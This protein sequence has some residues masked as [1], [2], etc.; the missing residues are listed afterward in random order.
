MAEII[1][2]THITG[3][4]HSQFIPKERFNIPK[5]TN[6]K[7]KSTI[8]SLNSG[9]VTQDNFKTSQS[10]P[11]SFVINPNNQT[12]IDL[13][14]CYFNVAGTLNINNADRKSVV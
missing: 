3:E 13:S 8:T 7:V 14:Q 2:N 11:F 1:E 10:T 4:Q 12:V 6:Q 5:S 9:L